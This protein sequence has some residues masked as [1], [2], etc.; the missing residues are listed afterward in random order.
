MDLYQKL[1]KNSKFKNEKLALNFNTI[2]NNESNFSPISSTI[3]YTRKSLTFKSQKSKT[4]GKF[5][6]KVITRIIEKIDMDNYNTKI[7]KNNYIIEQINEMTIS[8]NIIPEKNITNHDNDSN[9]PVV[10]S[11]RKTYLSGSLKKTNSSDLSKNINSFSTSR[12]SRNEYNKN[13]PITTSNMYSKTIIDNTG[14]TQ[15]SIS[16]KSFN[17]TKSSSNIPVSQDKNLCF[18]EKNEYSKQ[19]L[20]LK[21]NSGG[22]I[23]LFRKNSSEKIKNPESSSHRINEKMIS[24]VETLKQNPKI[25][26]SIDKILNRAQSIKYS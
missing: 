5:N 1:L 2:S 20:I 3:P 11:F 23:S 14:R 21:N 12:N 18:K 6:S 16:H 8:K 13:I 4:L 17:R 7:S 10:S 26:K 15:N 19:F 24:L 22:K 25:K 9:P